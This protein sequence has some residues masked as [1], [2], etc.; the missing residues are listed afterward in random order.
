MR[1]TWVTYD[2]QRSAQLEAAIYMIVLTLLM[3]KPCLSHPKV[4]F[5]VKVR[6]HWVC[7]VPIC[8]ELFKPVDS[9]RR[10]RALPLGQPGGVSLLS[11]CNEHHHQR[12]EATKCVHQFPRCLFVSV[13][14]AISGWKKSCT[15]LNGWNPINNGINSL[16]TG[17]GFLPSTVGHT[18]LY[19]M[20]YHLVHDE[21]TETG[22]GRLQSLPSGGHTCV[23]ED[24]R[25]FHG[26]RC[27]GQSWA[28]RG[29]T[30]GSSMLDAVGFF[31]SLAQN[32]FWTVLGSV[33]PWSLNT[34][35]PWK[36]TVSQL[37][38]SAHSP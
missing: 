4:C 17:A 36:V 31:C 25:F 13:V 6:L 14:D 12:G 2:Q 9:R 10:L 22:N 18:M 1:W 20:L 38:N 33:W 19:T 37:V 28:T 15:T 35:H 16:S 24:S 34:E 32:D 3:D 21:N 23:R 11:H 29:S 30:C 8:L 7:T 27:G 5:I 26:G